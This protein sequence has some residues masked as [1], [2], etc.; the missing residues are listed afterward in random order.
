MTPVPE[1]AAD[2]C[3]QIKAMMDS[4][5]PK[6]AVLI[7]PGNEAPAA[8][9]AGVYRVDRPAGVLM[10]RD[11]HRALAFADHSDDDA[12]MAWI[13]GYPEH[14]AAVVAACC[15]EP[16]RLA[17][18]VQARDAEGNVVTEAFTSPVGLERT[19]EAISAHVPKGGELLI[20]TPTEAITRRLFLRAVHG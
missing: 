11:P 2:I 18:A 20:M 5:H 15:G 4:E 7:V 10:T 13:L 3:A 8:T 14:K 19:I 1:P 9:A 12:A 6:Q 17:R 16:I